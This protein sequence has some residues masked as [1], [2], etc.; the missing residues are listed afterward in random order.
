MSIYD[1][2]VTDLWHAL[3]VRKDLCSLCGN[4][5]KIDTR[6]VTSSAGVVCGDVH[7]CI[8][9]NGQ[10]MRAYSPTATKIPMIAS[11][12]VN[13][14]DLLGGLVYENNG[15]FF[16]GNHGDADVTDEV[17]EIKAKIAMAIKG[18]VNDA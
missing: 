14:E 11:V 6:G 9:P 18:K 16:S 17:L 4:S 15:R 8:C 1:N 5:G 12:D 2:Y 13:I 10:A 7:Y 3:Y